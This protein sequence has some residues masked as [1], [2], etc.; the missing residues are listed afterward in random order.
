MMI[1]VKDVKKDYCDYYKKTN[2]SINQ[3]DK[4]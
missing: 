1:L 2:L 4:I 3:K